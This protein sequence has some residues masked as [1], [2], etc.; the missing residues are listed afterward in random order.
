M[1]FIDLQAQYQNHKREIDKSIQEVL[2]S[3]AY[4]MGLGS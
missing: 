4:I 1:Q 2:D 3:S